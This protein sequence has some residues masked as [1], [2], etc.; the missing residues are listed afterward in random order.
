MRLVFKAFRMDARDLASRSFFQ[1]TYEYEQPAIVS[2]SCQALH[3]SFAEQEPKE[4][5]LP[6][7]KSERFSGDSF[8]R[9][10]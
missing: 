9:F 8:I 6:S 10:E 2:M 7:E 5:M 1:T 3:L 4:A